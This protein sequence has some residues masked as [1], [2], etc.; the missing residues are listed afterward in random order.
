MKTIVTQATI[1][2]TINSNTYVVNVAKAGDHYK[3]DLRMTTSFKDYDKIL[4]F[5]SHLFDNV[6]WNYIQKEEPA[7]KKKGWIPKKVVK[8]SELDLE[9]IPEIMKVEPKKKKRG[10]PK[11]KPRWP[12]KPKVIDPFEVLSNAPDVLEENGYGCIDSL[13]D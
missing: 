1:I 3:V 12:R 13:V 8:T 2:E 6:K 4:N 10:R 11:G 9:K 7:P 5:L